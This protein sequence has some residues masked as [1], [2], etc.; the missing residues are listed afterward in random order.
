MHQNQ[1]ILIAIYY[2]RKMFDLVTVGHFTIDLTCSP[3]IVTPEPTLGG[4]PTYVSVAAKKL[5]AKVSLIS[6]VGEDFAHRHI[7]WLTAHGIDL[8]GLKMIKGASTTRFILNYVNWKRQLQ[9]KSQA[10]PIMPEDI[11]NSLRARVV[12]IAPVANEISPNI[13]D[14]LRKQTDTLSID[15]Q[16]FIREIDVNG[17]V[18]LKRWEDQLVLEQIDVYKSSHSEIRMATGLADLKLG[19]EKIRNYGAKIVIVTEGIKGSKLLFEGKLYD[20]PACKPKIVRDP[21]GAGDT[22]IGAFLVEYLAGK[23]P[24]WCACVGS[25]SASFVVE[26]VGTEVFGE[27]EDIYLRARKIYGKM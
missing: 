20:V 26:G 2:R 18:H 19:M 10:P 13:V 23:D 12:H 11:P 14:K 3:K 9:L 25:A 27:K 16:G 15:P 4:S 8:S 24:L 7:A 6:K 1:H 5:S 22:F 21:T 17:N